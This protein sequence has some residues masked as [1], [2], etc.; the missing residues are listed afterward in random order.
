MTRILIVDDERPFLQ[1]LGVSLRAR[2]YETYT[3]DSGGEGLR[4]AAEQHPDV[5]ILDLGLPDIDG[6]EALKAIRAWSTVPVLVLSARQAEAA[7]VSAL[8]AGAD[9]YVTK[10]F[11]FNELQA[12]LRAVLRRR[13]PSTE[14]ALIE[15]PDFS[16]DLPSKRIVGPGGE[17][18]LTPTEWRFVELLVRNEGKLVT[19][20]QILKEVWGPEYGTETDYLRTYIAAIRRKLEPQPSAPRYFITEPRMG[21]R[22]RRPD[23]VQTTHAAGS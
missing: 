15:T 5:L 1:A 16:I 6:L 4:L 9:D 11:S 7:K 19:Q 22:F 14:D 12:R 18:R 17:I 20:R 10:P 2:G 23:P 3:A 21:Y 13:L 8:D